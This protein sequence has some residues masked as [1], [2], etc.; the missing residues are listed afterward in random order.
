MKKIIIVL[1]T[2]I[3]ISCSENSSTESNFVL[4]SGVRFIL[5]NENE[6]DLLNSNTSGFYPL[7]SMKLYYKVNGEIIEV[8]DDNMELPRNI[9]LITETT[10]YQIGFASYSGYEGEISEI[11]GIKR[12]VSINYLEFNNGITDTIKVEWESKKDYYFVNNKIWYNKTLYNP[13]NLP[14]KVIKE[15][16]YR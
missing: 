9:G 1:F 12:G 16:N 13:D 10:P 8:Y 4:V 2:L 3:I 5:L 15:G 11:D 7:D 14:F 6:E